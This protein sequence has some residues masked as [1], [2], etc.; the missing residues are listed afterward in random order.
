MS[1]SPSIIE[2]L[3]IVL[4][5]G[6]SGT[7]FADAAGV[8]KLLVSS[9]SLAERRTELNASELAE[10]ADLPLFMF[11]VL[12]FAGLT[13]SGAFVIAVKPDD[14]PVFEKHLD[15]LPV[16]N[17]PRI[18]SG[19]AT[20]AESVLNALRAL[21]ESA[22]FAAVHDAARPLGTRK[23]MLDC[24]AAARK[25]GG[26]VAAKRMTDTLKRTDDDGFVLETLDRSDIWSVETPQIFKTRELREACEQAIESGVNPTDD[27]G[28]MELAGHRPFLFEY[29]GDNP[30]ITFA[31]D[32]Q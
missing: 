14:I 13:P 27:A 6:G 25:H 30:K 22:G 16:E 21:P 4:A 2:D 10:F 24:L 32:L 17:R 8:S 26:A 28:V 1:E 15:R 29:R 20:R 18:V 5:A 12:E 31:D 3:G 23:L 7:R 19:G 11:S 9:N